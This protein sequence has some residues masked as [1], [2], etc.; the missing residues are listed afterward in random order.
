[1]SSSVSMDSRPSRSPGTAYRDVAGEGGLVVLPGKAEVKVL[2]PVG[3]RVFA[4]LDGEHTVAQ[5]VAAVTDEFDVDR[6]RAAED[7]QQ[8]LAEL[9]AA[10]MLETQGSAT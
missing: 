6:A 1:M 2:N 7:V 10:G 8:F 9:A 4:L 3:S 5:I